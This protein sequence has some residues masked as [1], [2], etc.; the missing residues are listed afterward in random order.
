MGGESDRPARSGFIRGRTIRKTLGDCAAISPDQARALAEAFAAD[1]AGPKPEDLAQ[2]TL[3][4][5][6]PRYLEDC[7]GRWKPATLGAQRQGLR[8]FLPALGAREVARLT[9]EDVL[10]ARSGLTQAPATI[11]RAVAALSDLMRHAELIG[12]RHEGSNPCKGLRRH[13]S[14]F[15]AC[16]LTPDQYR[17]MGE[18]LRTAAREAPVAVACLRFL[19]LTGCRRAEA[20]GL[21]WGWIDGARAALPDAKAGPKSLWLGRPVRRLL[22][23]L[24][25]SGLLVFAGPDSGP[26]A[27]AELDRIWRAVRDRLGLPHLRL[28]DLRHSLASSA[29]GM[30]HSLEVISGLLGHLDRRST[31]GYAHLNTAPVIAAS[32]RVGNHLQKVLA[33]TA[34]DGTLPDRVFEDYLNSRD[35]LPVW[36]KAQGLDPEAFSAALR[37]YRQRRFG[38][39]AQR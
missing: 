6:L 9:R 35:R 33:S 13:K 38:R 14:D 30:G 2:V 8:I 23:S 7:A 1:L 12:L 16:Y 26:L 29:I 36:C 37:A 27:A 20:L 17:E 19:A 21:E 18:V 31:A 22:S 24:P 32:T 25:R 3:S 4:G 15:E 11:S 34:P 10:A 5:F 39:R 28:H